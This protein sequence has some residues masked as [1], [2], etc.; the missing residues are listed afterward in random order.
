LE[1]ARKATKAIAF[2]DTL[3]E[4]FK[5]LIGTMLSARTR[6]ETTAQVCRALFKK[7][8]NFQDILDMPAPELEKLIK[9]IGFYKTKVRYMK[10]IA[11]KIMSEYGGEI[12][13]T[14]DDLVRLPGVGRKTANLVVAVA[15]GKPSVCVDTH[16]HRI[17]NRTGIVKTKTP[18]QTEKV[19]RKTA[20]IY[21]WSEINRRFVPFGKRI[22]TPISPHCSICPLDNKCPKIGVTQSR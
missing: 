1:G 10:G 7:V 22:C 2:G 5:S 18:G 20:P 3:K 6:D 16:V 12:P 21:L 13:D 9:P 15:F 19:L 11:E 8:K 4:P 17:C 14:I